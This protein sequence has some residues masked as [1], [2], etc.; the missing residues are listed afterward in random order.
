MRQRWDGQLVTIRIKKI[1]PS[2]NLELDE[3][4]G[5]GADP[6]V[7]QLYKTGTYRDKWSKG[8]GPHISM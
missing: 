3:T 7:Q 6:D 4:D 8:F 5:I 2:G 1:H